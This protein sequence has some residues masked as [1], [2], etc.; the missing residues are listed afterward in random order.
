V[1]LDSPL[2]SAPC[3]D[4]SRRQLPSTPPIMS[5]CGIFSTFFRFFPTMDSATLH[6]CSGWLRSF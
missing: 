3:A 1:R 2:R 4:Q 5:R 6:S